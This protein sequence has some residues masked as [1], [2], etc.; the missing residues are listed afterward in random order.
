MTEYTDSHRLYT[1]DNNTARIDFVSDSCVRVAIYKNNAAMLPTFSVNPEN[2]FSANGRSRLDT[3]GF[4]M[5]NPE[6]TENENT[7]SFALPCGITIELQTDNFLLKYSKQNSVLFADRAPLAYNFENEF[8]RES[9]H[10]ITRMSG[11]RVFG[12]GDKGGDL[13]KA[14]RAF[15]I[16]TSDCMGYDASESDPLYKHVPFYICENSVGCYGIFYDTSDN[17]YIDLG[18][19]INNY[20]APY[21]YFK[22]ED[23]CLVYYVF[24]GT[25]LSVLQQFVKLCG[26]QAFPPKWSFDYCASTMAYTD[27][28]QSY[29]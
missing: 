25:K 29:E 21:K 6:I 26:K 3:T 1:C 8:G 18:K 13:N 7:E 27:A 28:P 11:E 12:L 22:T 17:S 19:E 23:E 9:Y 16:E 15:R 2:V 5:C 10:Y 24:F 14:G 20:Y 4:P